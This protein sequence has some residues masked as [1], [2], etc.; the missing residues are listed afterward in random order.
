M[1]SRR[2]FLAATGATVA[3]LAG[4]LAGPGPRRAADPYLERTTGTETTE[5]GTVR[6]TVSGRLRLDRGEFAVHAFEN[7]EPMVVSLRASTVLSLPFDV[8]TLQ[9][10]ELPAYAAGEDVDPL[11]TASSFGGTGSRFRARLP[12]GRY[13]TVFDNTGQWPTRPLDR[14]TIRFEFGLER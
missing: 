1:T 2:R 4:C 13:V 12:A 5:D 11:S 9:A 14:I 7:D 6:E 10:D 8:G 3:A